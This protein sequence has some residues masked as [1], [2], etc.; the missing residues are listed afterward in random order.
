VSGRL[1]GTPLERALMP[2]SD[3][4][5]LKCRDHFESI[6][7]RKRHSMLPVTGCPPHFGSNKSPATRRPT[8]S[9]A[10]SL[11]TRVF[12]DSRT[13]AGPPDA[14]RN[15]NA[16]TSSGSRVEPHSARTLQRRSSQQLSLRGAE[17]GQQ[18]EQHLV[19]GQFLSAT[20]HPQRGRSDL[21]S[22]AL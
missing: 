15:L 14:R 4:G 12:L 7:C 17:R 10:S 1:A 13:P 19:H 3:S 6:K 18:F 8:R 16:Y 22:Q 5:S 9:V 2:H 20:K 21:M 11:P